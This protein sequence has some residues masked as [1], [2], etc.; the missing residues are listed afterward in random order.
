MGQLPNIGLQN[1]VLGFEDKTT[2]N[3]NSTLTLYPTGQEFSGSVR[4]CLVDDVITVFTRLDADPAWTEQ[5][6]F[7]H[8]IG[9]TLGAGVMINDFQAGNAEVEG[10]FEYVR[11]RDIDSVD[12]CR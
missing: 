12:D 11:F 1:G 10:Q 4:L 3:D 5:N 2:V 9:T 7:T 8:A 6:S